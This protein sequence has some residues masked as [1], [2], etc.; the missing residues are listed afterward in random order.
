MRT[1]LVNHKK[2]FSVLGLVLLLPVLAGAWS[3]TAGT[4]GRLNARFDLWQGRYAIHTYGLNLWGR[5]YAGILK[6]RYGIETHVDALCIVSQSEIAYADSYNKLSTAAAKRR[7][8]HDVFKECNE[9]A[10]RNWELS[11]AQNVGKN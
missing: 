9:E 11:R 4:R 3:L 5:E 8:G 7:F 10:R 1:F 2:L 6:D